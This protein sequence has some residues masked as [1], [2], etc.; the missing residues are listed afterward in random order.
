MIVNECTHLARQAEQWLPGPASQ[1][2]RTALLRWL[3]VFPLCLMVHLRG[4]DEE[5]P[6]LVKGCVTPYCCFAQ[7]QASMLNTQQILRC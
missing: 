7:C 6:A 4:E 2:V 5:L 3:R 1:P